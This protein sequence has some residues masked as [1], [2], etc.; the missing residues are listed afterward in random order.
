[1]MTGLAIKKR[2]VQ[3]VAANLVGLGLVLF[4]AGSTYARNAVEG[5]GGVLVSKT[6]DLKTKTTRAQLA[7][8]R[9]ID[10]SNYE[11][12]RKEGSA[13]IP[14]YFDGD[15]KSFDEKRKTH[16]QKE[17]YTSSTFQ[18]S[19]ELRIETPDAAIKAWVECVRLQTKNA[20]LT[21]YAKDVDKTGATVVVEWSPAAGLGSLER[22]KVDA[23]GI[24]EP[25]SLLD[26]NQLSADGE[27]SFIIERVAENA[28]VRGVVRG[29]AGAKGHYTADF[30]IPAKL[31]EPPKPTPPCVE[32]NT[33]GQC[34]RCSGTETV[35]SG[36]RGENL[37]IL[38]C[39]NVNPMSRYWA[40]V[41]GTLS[42]TGG[43]PMTGATLEFYLYGPE[44][45][46]LP[47]MPYRYQSQYFNDKIDVRWDT[48]GLMSGPI[49]TTVAKSRIMVAV[50]A[51]GGR[52]LD[53]EINNLR[54]DIC[55]EEASCK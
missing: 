43:I 22:V 50:C 10:E 46:R 36:G 8:M 2:L 45:S 52:Q 25:S 35:A 5:C 34:M 27:Q 12:A 4:V 54:W 33:N 3:F 9:L 21:I 42:S 38:E 29:E 51:S 39:A 53:C 14:G 48:F 6:V 47:G 16:F 30:Y 17:N 18:A 15:F 13:L 37:F 44:N 49:G 20:G 19:E 1:M 32:I 23:Q 11:S 7:W 41:S 40:R 26:L 24:K 28:V 31:T 55:A